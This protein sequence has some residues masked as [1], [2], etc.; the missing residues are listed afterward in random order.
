MTSLMVINRNIFSPCNVSFMFYLTHTAPCARL[1][2]EAALSENET[3]YNQPS[4]GPEELPGE[5]TPV[6]SAHTV[7]NQGL[8]GT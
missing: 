8:A 4:E 3:E 5:A 6:F 1:R 2:T 7:S